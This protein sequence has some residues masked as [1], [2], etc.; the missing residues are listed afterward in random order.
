MTA[1]ATLSP[2]SDTGRPGLAATIAI[3]LIAS[4]AVFGLLVAGTVF[5]ALAVGF[6]TAIPIAQHYRVSV[7]A[8]DMAVAARLA[9]LWWVPGVISIASFLGAVVVGIAAVW[10]LGAVRGR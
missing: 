10:R 1:S 7:S 5:L 4:A 6:E 9:E 2:S 3:G 8:A